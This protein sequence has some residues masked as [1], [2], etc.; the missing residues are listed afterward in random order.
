MIGSKHKR[1]R[2]AIHSMLTNRWLPRALPRD[3]MDSSESCSTWEQRKLRIYP[4][5]SHLS[6]VEGCSQVR[7]LFGTSGLSCAQLWKSTGQ[8]ERRMSRKL[9]VCTEQPTA[10]VGSADK[11]C[12]HSDNSVRGMAKLFT[13]WLGTPNHRDLPKGGHSGY[14]FSGWFVWGFYDSL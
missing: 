1:V 5:D 12:C 2:K 6:L 13:R 7:W 11:V 4:P 10:G 9:V 14:V 3:C 8:A